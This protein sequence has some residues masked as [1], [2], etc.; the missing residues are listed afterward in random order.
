M[1]VNIKVHSVYKSYFSDTNLTVDLTSFMELQRYLAT[2]QPKFINYIRD[3]K[4]IG[5]EEGFTYLDSEF[6]E[7]T[8]RRKQIEVKLIKIIARTSWFDFIIKS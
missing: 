1:Q 5:I 4:E 7:I 3:Q 6:K 2:M 8:T